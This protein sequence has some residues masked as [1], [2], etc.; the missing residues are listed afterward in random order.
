MPA[1]KKRS[2][3][4]RARGPPDPRAEPA[5][6]PPTP[7]PTPVL[8]GGHRLAALPEPPHTHLVCRACARIVEVPME[9]DQQQ[10]LEGLLLRAPS[11]WM[12]DSI[13]VSMTGACPRCR[14][15]PA[16]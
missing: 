5:P 8:T 1:A 11:G 12:I 16:A 9:F 14:Q 7:P 2:P 15:G 6:P 13:T 4:K 3:R 10:S